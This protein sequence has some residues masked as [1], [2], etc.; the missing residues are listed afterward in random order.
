MKCPQNAWCNR[1]LQ[2]CG[3]QLFF[4]NFLFKKLSPFEP[5]FDGFYR[6]K[7]GKR[8]E[9]YKKQKS[10]EIIAACP[11]CLLIDAEVRTCPRGM[12]NSHGIAFASTARPIR[13]NHHLCTSF[14]RIITYTTIIM[15]NPCHFKN[16]KSTNRTS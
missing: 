3:L 9:N 11:L 2:S 13:Q 4:N 5:I 6:I 10:R 7:C 12:G 15:Q 16:Q 14:F 1:H 8:K